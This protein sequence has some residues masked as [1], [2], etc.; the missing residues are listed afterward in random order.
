MPGSEPGQGRSPG[1]AV[2]PQWPGLRPA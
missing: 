1:S 2:P